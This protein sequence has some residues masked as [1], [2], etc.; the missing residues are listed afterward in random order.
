M[1]IDENI[2]DGDGMVDDDDDDDGDDLDDQVDEI[3][4]IR[5]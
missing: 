4:S 1:D 3:S 2:D 5:R